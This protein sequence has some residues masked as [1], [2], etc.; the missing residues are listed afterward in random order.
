MA[1][2]TTTPDERALSDGADEAHPPTRTPIREELHAA[3][4]GPNARPGA[5]PGIATGSDAAPIDR[6]EPI[7]PGGAGGPGAPLTT[8]GAVGAANT[9]WMQMLRELSPKVY[10]LVLASLSV[11]GILGTYVLIQSAFFPEKVRPWIESAGAL[12][13]V[14]FAAAFA[15]ATGSAVLPTYALSFA[16]GVMLGWEAGAFV[17][18]TGVTVGALVGYGWGNLLARSDVMAVIERHERARLVRSALLDR[19]LRDETMMVGLL[20]FPP[21]SPFALTNLAMSSTAVRLL[22][23]AIGT[24]VGMAPRTLLAVWIGTQRDSVADFK[25]TGWMPLAG[26]AVALVVFFCVYRLFSKWAR[27]AL[28]KRIS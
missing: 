27:E 3:T 17:A 5:E 10:I 13:V 28:N 23:F 7:E 20:R 8:P 22:P 9:G 11:P 6:L 25:D 1:H 18:V 19:S 4:H 16:A 12:G 15:V 26:I 24:A 2:G 21:N 14:A